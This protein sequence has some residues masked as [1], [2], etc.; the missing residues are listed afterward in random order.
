MRTSLINAE[1]HMATTKNA[2]TY[3]GSTNKVSSAWDSQGG[4]AITEEVASTKNGW[5]VAGNAVINTF[6]ML[7]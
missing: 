6:A 3:L 2:E 5:A 7:G 1:A 4:K